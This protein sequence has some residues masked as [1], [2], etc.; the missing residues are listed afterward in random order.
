[1]RIKEYIKLQNILDFVDERMN[2]PVIFNMKVI[3]GNELSWVYL[4]YLWV[5]FI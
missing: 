3:Y 1:M 4:F 2:M 5:E